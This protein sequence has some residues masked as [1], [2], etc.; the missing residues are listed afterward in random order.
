MHMLTRHE[1]SRRTIIIVPDLSELGLVGALLDSEASTTLF[2]LEILNSP[3]D[4]PP[5]HARAAHMYT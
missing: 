4:E 2:F 1:S 5:A 3:V